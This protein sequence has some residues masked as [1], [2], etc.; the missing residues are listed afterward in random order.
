VAAL[1]LAAAFIASFFSTAACAQ[2]APAD[3]R[4]SVRFVTEPE[5]EP[6]PPLVDD[7]LSRL[8]A[9]DAQLLLVADAAWSPLDSQPVDSEPVG[10]QPL[11][12]VDA[13]F[14]APPGPNPSESDGNELELPV[15][16]EEPESASADASSCETEV[17]LVSTR[18]LPHCGEHAPSNF[19][20]EVWRHDRPGGWVRATIEEFVA[21]P[22]AALPTTILVHGNQSTLKDAIHQGWQVKRQLANQ[23][24]AQRVVIWTWP[25]DRVLGTIFRDVKVK[26]RAADIDGF[27]FGWFLAQ[28]KPPAPVTLIGFS[29]GA[30]VIVSG[31]HYRAGGLSSRSEALPVEAATPPPLRVVLMAAA[32]DR[33]WI[34]PGARY[35]HALDQIDRLLLMVNPRDRVLRWFPRLPGGSG[36]EAL[37]YAGLCGLKRGAHFDKIVQINVTSLVRRR[38]A[39]KHY[40]GSR[41][42]MSRLRREVD[43]AS[44]LLDETTGAPEEDVRD[45]P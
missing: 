3:V 38:H 15:L 34:A 31:L 35:E 26:A 19:D 9:D 42:V 5:A 6:E 10:A 28:L 12:P 27:Y 45:A 40:V 41:P 37:G 23:A 13:I 17:W 20:L 18:R 2:E 11:A 43:E 25:S 39:W 8:S 44:L 1:S 22:S 4:G 7:D 32:I 16:P 30:K 36:G 33:S 21:G 24:G 14:A 29:Y